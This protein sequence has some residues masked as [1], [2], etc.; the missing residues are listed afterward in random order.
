[1]SMQ[2]KTTVKKREARLKVNEDI[3]ERLIDILACVL[4]STGLTNAM[5]TAMAFETALWYCLALTLAAMAFV[6]LFSRVFWVAPLLIFATAT[7]VLVV[8]LF[9]Q[10]VDETAKYWA[11]F[12]KWWASAMPQQYPYSGN[13]SL[14][15]IQ[16]CFVFLLVSVMYLLMRKLCSVAFFSLLTAAAAITMYSIGYHDILTMSI[17]GC[18]GIVVLLPRVFFNYI[19]KTMPEGQRISRVPMQL[20][21]VPIALGAVLFALVITP[22]NTYNWR[23]DFLV[24]NINDVKD[25]IGYYT[26]QSGAHPRFSIKVSGFMP[27]GDRLGGPVEPNNIR[28]FSVLTDNPSVM[29]GGVQ[30]YY[31]GNSWIDSGRDGYFRL[32]SLLWRGRRKT[33]FNFKNP[34]GGSEAQVLFDKMTVTTEATVNYGT[35]SSYFVFSNGRVLDLSLSSDMYPYFDMQSEIFTRYTMDTYST[36]TYTTLMFDRALEGFDENMLELEK[37]AGAEEDADYESIAA[38]YLQLPDEMPDWIRLVAR[39]ITDG[40]EDPYEKA[41]AIELWL[42]ENFTYTLTPD[43]P[44]ED[45]D[46]VAHFLQTKE[47]Y[48]TY[49]ATAMAVLARSADL[50]ARY[51]TGY[52]LRENENFSNAYIA[53]NATAHA[54][55]EIYFSG[56]GWMGFDPLMWNSQVTA[57]TDTITH[58]QDDQAGDQSGQE[59]QSGQDTPIPQEDTIDTSGQPAQGFFRSAVIL[60][61]I[62]LLLIILRIA[63]SILMG[64]YHRKYRLEKV[65]RKFDNMSDR[66]AFYYADILRQMRYFGVEVQT[67]DT[68]ITFAEKADKRVHVGDARMIQI[69]EMMMRDKYGLLPTRDSQ[70]QKLYFFHAE[71]ERELKDHLGAW[72]YFWRRVIFG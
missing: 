53:T 60:G 13:G 66:L 32:N 27:E 4:L 54:W 6:Y 10:T 42:A 12:F 26:G 45:E 68:F 41:K 48:C 3:T 34:L 72:S 71:L 1:M 5:F 69:A 64:R 21:A 29:K 17:L 36:Y 49:Y 57:V 63:V 47:G 8:A 52:G 7:T 67:G 15:I 22:E 16:F 28:V 35:W 62:I 25:F 44:P 14:L 59:D 43:V 40:I 9:R 61:S 19:K 18:S 23:S 58:G 55:V 11:G 31:T 46:F 33:V 20:L 56:I 30:D 39:T 37:L 38:K 2:I 24:R 65:I 50:P 51:V 70:L